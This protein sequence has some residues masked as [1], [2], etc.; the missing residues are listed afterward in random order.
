[1]PIHHVFDGPAAIPPRVRG[2]RSATYPS[3]WLN[4][5][6]PLQAPSPIRHTTATTRGSEQTPWTPAIHVLASITWFIQDKRHKETF[7]C[8]DHTLKQQL[9][10]G[11]H[12]RRKETWP[13]YVSF[14]VAVAA[15]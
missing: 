11:E 7:V 12:A 9:I 1:V 6:P 13:C 5:L 4:Q 8:T 14:I 3:P 15:S 2:L 10:V